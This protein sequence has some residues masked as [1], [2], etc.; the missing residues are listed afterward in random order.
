VIID[1][2]V[3]RVEVCDEPYWHMPDNNYPFG[4]IFYNNTACGLGVIF[5]HSVISASAPFGDAVQSPY[6]AFNNNKE[7]E[8]VFEEV[9]TKDFPELPS[10]LKAFYLFDHLKLAERD[11]RE[12]FGNSPRTLVECRL[13]RDARFHRADCTW[14]NSSQDQWPEMARRYWSGEMSEAPFPEIVLHGGIY[15]L[16]WQNFKKMAEVTAALNEPHKGSDMLGDSN[17]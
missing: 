16:H 7:K 12:W 1:C 14:L 11:N 4:E 17:G 15:C 10:R 5:S 13:L 8:R 6:S 3:G 9:R 2:H